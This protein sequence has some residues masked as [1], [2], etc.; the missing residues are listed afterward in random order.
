MSEN[1]ENK[2][3]IEKI[4]SAL[5]PEE[6]KRLRKEYRQLVAD[7]F[8]SARN[9]KGTEPEV[10]DVLEH[11][12]ILDDWIRHNI[13]GSKALSLEEERQLNDVFHTPE[14]DRT[15]QGLMD[16]THERFEKWLEASD[17]NEP[18]NVTLED[19]NIHTVE[20]DGIILPPQENIKPITPGKIP[21]EK[22]P[23]VP[24]LA[25]L[26]AFLNQHEI[27]TDD[28]V[29]LPGKL[30]PGVMR[31]ET[32]YIIEIPRLNKEILVCNQVNEATFVIDGIVDR[33]TLITKNKAQLKEHLGNRM[34][35]ITYSNR[36]YWER[37]LYEELFEPKS[38]KDTQ[39]GAPKKPAI[40]PKVDIPSAE[41]IKEK[42]QKKYTAEQFV[43]MPNKKRRDIEV[44]GI[45]MTAISTILGVPGQVL[46]NNILYLETAER[47]YGADHPYVKEK[48]E[49]A[50]L[51]RKMQAELGEDPEKWR[52][53]IKE[54]ITPEEWSRLKGKRI[55]EFNVYGLTLK[56]LSKIFDFNDYKESKHD[57]YWLGILIFGDDC[58]ELN[59]A[60]EVENDKQIIKNVLG[61]DPEKWREAINKKYPPKVW[62]ELWRK[63]Q[64][65]QITVHGKK[66]TFLGAVFG[67][68]HGDDVVSMKHL[69]KGM[70]FELSEAIYGKAK[71]KQTLEQLEEED[72]IEQAKQT[73]KWRRLIKDK[74]SAEEWMSRGPKKRKEIEV[75][76]LKVIALASKLGLYLD[77]HSS[78]L[79]YY[80]MAAVIYGE[81]NPHVKQ[82]LQEERFNQE[83][84]DKLGKDKD[85]WAEEI[86][87][88][89][90][91]E[92]WLSFNTSS[93]N[94]FEIYGKK[95][96]S[97]AKIFGIKNIHLN[98]SLNILKIGAMIY[99]DI[100]EITQEID[101]LTSAA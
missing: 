10:D 63:G 56:N 52:K 48:L 33:N 97:I 70:V 24:R 13:G 60:F 37:R 85:M 25:E 15:I 74:Y 42:L 65:E 23:I 8:K 14:K 2:N 95:I 59:N 26:V 9:Y 88:Y 22:A 90:T 72:K 34:S 20:L 57:A 19:L 28:I 89:Y 35:K 53:A 54:K 99:G 31:D 16:F 78:N 11:L 84:R 21:F 45:K 98:K 83:M 80:E 75:N 36:S 62:M 92:D 49:E 32:Y 17:E 51:N 94:D 81:N 41:V 27:Y 61:R 30:L 93:I 58:E 66:T 55:R 68:V 87:K 40:G 7:A 69:N 91:L 79:T 3:K 6:V 12:E 4:L 67:I 47:I 5:P 96:G 1:S 29:V 44:N 86:R 100:P 77:S 43:D 39:E 46:S 18:P 71:V 76:G 38:E 101:R 73:K 82:K 50:K 64:Y